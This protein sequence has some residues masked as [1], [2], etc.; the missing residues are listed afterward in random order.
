MFWPMATVCA[1]R[2]MIF[3]RTCWLPGLLEASQPTSHRQETRKAK[4][5]MMWFQMCRDFGGVLRTI[6][7]RDGVD[8]RSLTYTSRVLG[9]RIFKANVNNARSLAEMEICSSCALFLGL[10]PECLDAP[11]PTDYCPNADHRPA[12]DR[13]ELHYKCLACTEYYCVPYV[14]LSAANVSTLLDLASHPLIDPRLVS[15]MR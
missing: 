4:M 13:R 3:C 12:S 1:E 15:S 2:S 14:L 11:G 9:F 6:N 10:N 8:K 7:W 5:R